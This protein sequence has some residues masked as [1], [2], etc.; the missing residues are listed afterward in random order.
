[1]S[2]RKIR[3][4]FSSCCVLYVPLPAFPLFSNSF[5]FLNIL[6]LLVILFF[7]V[8]SFALFVKFLLLFFRRSFPCFPSSSFYSLPFFLFSK[9]SISASSIFPFV[10][11]LFYTFFIFISF[12]YSPLFFFPLLVQL[13]IFFHQFYLLSLFSSFFSIFLDLFLPSLALLPP[14]LEFQCDSCQ[15]SNLFFVR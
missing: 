4:S 10:I 1:M 7:I 12:L 13:I 5:P 3:T 9:S 2:V 14:F 15:F 6:P 11:V 8:T